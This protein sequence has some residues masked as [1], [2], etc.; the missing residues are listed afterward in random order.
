MAIYSGF[1]YWNWWFSI[2]M[3]VY[4]RV[5]TSKLG[6]HGFLASIPIGSILRSTACSK[7]GYRPCPFFE[8]HS[9]SMSKSWIPGKSGGKH[10]HHHLLLV[11]G[12]NHLEKYE[13]Q[14]EGWH[15]YMKWKIKNV[16]NHQPV[17][18]FFL[19]LDG[20]W[21]NDP[22]DPIHIHH[23]YEQ[24]IPFPNSLRSTRKSSQSFTITTHHQSLLIITNDY[25]QFP[26]YYC[27]NY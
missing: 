4:Q 22:K 5:P 24:I 15:P 12:F 20:K 6:H 16:W 17:F 8:Q 14:W 2:A 9:M 23:N 3:L 25:H 19:V 7:G 1:A 26:T 21:G 11:G 10:H 18:F 27:S 13:S